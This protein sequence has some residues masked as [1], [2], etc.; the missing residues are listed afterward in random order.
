MN[1]FVLDSN[2]ILCAQYHCDKHVIKMILESVQILSTVVRL[3]GIDQG[4]RITHQNHPAVKWVQESLTNWNWLKVL[5]FELNKEYRYR[6][7]K[8][9]DHKSISVLLSLSEP[10]IQNIPL[11][12]FSQIVPKKYQ[13]PDPILAYRKYYYYEKSSICSWKKR[14]PPLWWYELDSNH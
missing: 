11:T 1:I 9:V 4:Y 13:D 7:D 5:T 6:F 8:I 2:P 3:N 10:D 12:P 14:N